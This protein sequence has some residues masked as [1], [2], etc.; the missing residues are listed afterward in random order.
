[1]FSQLSQDDTIRD[2]V[3]ID[4]LKKSR[5]GVKEK[6]NIKQLLSDKRLSD[7]KGKFIHCYADS[8]DTRMGPPIISSYFFQLKHHL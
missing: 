1:M 4:S 6:S 2:M 7:E 8:L 3:E 5:G